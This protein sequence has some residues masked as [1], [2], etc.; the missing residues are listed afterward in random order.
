MLN[1][2]PPRDD[3]SYIGDVLIALAAETE[4]TTEQFHRDKS[5]L[6][7]NGCYY[8]FN[9][10]RGLEDIGLEESKTKNEIAAVTGRYICPSR[11]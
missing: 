3:I 7:D 10:L 2:K 6:Y 1:L 9:V 4:Q 11:I 5:S 8:C